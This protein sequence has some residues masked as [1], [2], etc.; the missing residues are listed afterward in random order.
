M[1]GRIRLAAACTDAD[2]SDAVSITMRYR[3]A[4]DD[5]LAF[6]FAPARS[7]PSWS[8]PRG[9]ECEIFAGQP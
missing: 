2:A 8:L 7:F 5:F 4:V 6:P 9:P 3:D 1:D